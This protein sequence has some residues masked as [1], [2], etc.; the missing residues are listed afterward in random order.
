MEQNSRNRPQRLSQTTSMGRLARSSIPTA[1][2]V[3]RRVTP[4]RSATPIVVK[5]RPQGVLGSTYTGLA[6]LE[7]KRPSQSAMRAMRSL[8]PEALANLIGFKELMRRLRKGKLLPPRIN[9]VTPWIYRSTRWHARP[10]TYGLRG[11][12]RWI[13]YRLR[14]RAR[15]RAG[16]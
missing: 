2:H 14:A 9:K 4:E 3:T 10:R 11:A 15:G 1:L 8:K 12:S 6:G 13:L 16:A 5:D 7:A